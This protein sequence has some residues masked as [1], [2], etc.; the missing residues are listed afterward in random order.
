MVTQD[1]LQRTHNI[2]RAI[3]K[4]SFKAVEIGCGVILALDGGG[5]KPYIKPRSNAQSAYN[6]ECLWSKTKIMAFG[7]DT[8]ELL[9]GVYDNKTNTVTFTNTQLQW[10]S[11]KRLGL[12]Q[13]LLQSFTKLRPDITIKIERS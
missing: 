1:L 2:V 4:R 6:G 9:V 8:G 3:D 11:S 10:L 5:K 7:D 12:P 13:S